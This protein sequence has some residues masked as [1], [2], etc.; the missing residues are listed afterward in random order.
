MTMALTGLHYDYD[1]NYVHDRD[2]F[3]QLRE[4]RD[5]AEGRNL[6]TALRPHFDGVRSIAFGYGFDL[7]VRVS[8]D[9]R[10]T[11]GQAVAEITGYFNDLNNRPGV[12]GH[13]RFNA[14]RYNS[15]APSQASS[16]PCP[17]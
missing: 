7:L 13:V 5:L 4:N 14:E 1:R 15:L 2:T 10:L 9:P 17:Y 12:V 8:P 16:A 3:L 11:D 6:Q